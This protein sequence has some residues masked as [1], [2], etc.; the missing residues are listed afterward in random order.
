MQGEAVFYEMHV[1]GTRGRPEPLT[2]KF[3]TGSHGPKGQG[4]RSNESRNMK[5]EETNQIV[6][7][8]TLFFKS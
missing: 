7:V 2:L 1:T 8:I 4:S 3:H 5:T 6:I